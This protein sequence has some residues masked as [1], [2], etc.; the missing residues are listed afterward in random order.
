MR[1]KLIIDQ[2]GKLLVQLLLS[3]IKQNPITFKNSKLLQVHMTPIVFLECLL[4]APVSS[5]IRTGTASC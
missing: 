5:I 2:G 4:L 3:Q 1:E